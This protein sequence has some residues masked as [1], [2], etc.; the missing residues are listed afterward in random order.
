MQLRVSQML[1]AHHGRGE[2]LRRCE[3]LGMR[4]VGVDDQHDEQQHEER[5]A[6]VED[7][8]RHLLVNAEQTLGIEAGGTEILPV[9]ETALGC[10]RGA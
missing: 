4:C 9:C 5:R 10:R 6:A 1:A 7:V 3:R 8:A 2:R